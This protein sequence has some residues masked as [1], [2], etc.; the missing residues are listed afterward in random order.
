[1]GWWPLVVEKFHSVCDVGSNVMN[2]LFE[3]LEHFLV[4]FGNDGCTIWYKS[5]VDKPPNVKENNKHGL[6]F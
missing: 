1:M 3:S 5:M 2:P 4:E 6:N